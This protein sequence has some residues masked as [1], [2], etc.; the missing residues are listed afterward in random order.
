MTH[1]AFSPLLGCE[2]DNFLFASIGNDQNGTPL[3]VLSA[4]ARFDVD[5]WQETAALAGMPKE[6]ATE[7][8]AVLIGAASADLATGLYAETIAARLV[9]LLPQAPIYKRAAPAGLFQA[10]AF[11]PSRL[12]IPLGLLALSLAGYYI[13]VGHP[14]PAGSPNSAAT[15]SDASN[16]R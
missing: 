7:R 9:A 1:S 13:F 6:R 11:A 15:T 14:S 12:F 5:P 2:F 10:A 16:P 4:L 3:S 8:L